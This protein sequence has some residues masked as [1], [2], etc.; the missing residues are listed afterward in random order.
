MNA[1][2][3]K[4]FLWALFRVSERRFMFS[5]KE[6]CWRFFKLNACFSIIFVANLF[7]SPGLFLTI[8]LHGLWAKD[9]LYNIG[10]FLCSV[11][12]PTKNIWCLGGLRWCKANGRRN[13]GSSQELVPYPRGRRFKPTPA[14][15][16]SWLRIVPKLFAKISG[17]WRSP[18]K[19]SVCHRCKTRDKWGRAAQ[20]N[21]KSAHIVTTR[22]QSRPRSSAAQKL[23]RKIAEDF[24]FCFYSL[25]LCVDHFCVEFADISL[26]T[27]LCH[28][29]ETGRLLLNAMIVR[30]KWKWLKS[31]IILAQDLLGVR[32]PHIV[33]ESYLTSV[34]LSSSS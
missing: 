29:R 19:T 25:N 23:R 11:A 1:A 31:R 2:W 12:L 6:V 17:W 5:G 9:T 22:A 4:N 10:L 16:S 18:A 3:L 21:L 34:K 26:S 7:N 20:S 8:K 32:Q 13:G 24:H 27:L 28:M 14:F 15:F 30:E 33:E